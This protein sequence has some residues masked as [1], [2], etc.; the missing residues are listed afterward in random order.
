MEVKTQ[1]VK[2]GFLRKVYKNE[3]IDL[4]KWINKKDCLYV[5]R[6]G[7]IFI[8]QKDGTNKIFHYKE[9]KWAN[10]FKVGEGEGKYSLDESIEFYRNHVLNSDLKKDLAE[11]SGKTLGCFCD[12]K[13]KCHAKV[14]AELFNEL[15]I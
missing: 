15:V 12:Q 11:L 13:G 6:R 10:P 1:C 2:V 14:L 3:D 8:K 4:E 7:R 5:G 9:S